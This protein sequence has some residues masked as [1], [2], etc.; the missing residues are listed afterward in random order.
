M[1]FFFF[2]Y[3]PYI[4]I[5]GDIKGSRTLEDR[6]DIQ[7]RLGD[8]LDKINTKYETDISSKFIITLGDEFQGLLF[9]GAHVMDILFEIQKHMYPVRIRFGVGIGAITTEINKEWAIGADGPG[10]YHARKAVEHLKNLE[11]KNRS[12][13]ADIFLEA[14]EVNQGTAVMIN[15]VLSLMTVLKESWSDRQRE[16]IWDMLE[17]QDNQKDVACRLE[18]KQP[19]VQK[20]LAS[21]N[22]YS[23]KNAFDTVE[24]ALGEIHR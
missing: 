6:K 5:I 11:K 19:S 4:A 14:D 10:Y 12:N 7:K 17:H 23:Y 22:Y 20:S 16:V 15:A 3:N 18:I 13:E 2:D 1:M 24:R 8:I 21:G 9:D